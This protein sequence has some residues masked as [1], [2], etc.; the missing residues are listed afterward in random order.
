VSQR[1]AFHICLWMFTMSEA[2]VWT[3]PAGELVDR[4]N[5]PWDSPLRRPS[6]AHKLRAWRCAMHEVSESTV[7][8]ERL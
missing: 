6:L 3:R 2:W 8:D 7:V 1:G 5:S 4:S